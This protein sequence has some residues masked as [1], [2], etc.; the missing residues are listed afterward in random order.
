MDSN[1]TMDT[2]W[3]AKGAQLTGRQVQDFIKDQFR[4]LISKNETIEQQLTSQKIEPVTDAE[5]EEIC[6]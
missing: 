1:I 5:I 6:T 4:S 2:D 3:G